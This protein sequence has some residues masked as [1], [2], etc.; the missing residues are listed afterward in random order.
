MDETNSLIEQR[1]S[2]LAKLREKGIDPFK[3][4]VA[5]TLGCGEARAKYVAKELQDGDHVITTDLEHNS[6]SRPLR[7][8]ELDGRIQLTR[9]KADGGGTI[10]PEEI[11]KAITSRTRSGPQ[12]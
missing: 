6:V 1:K 7:K 2:N 12:A 10:N 5:P 11:R 9:A 3:N 4:K 8:M